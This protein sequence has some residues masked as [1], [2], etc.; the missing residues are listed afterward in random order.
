MAIRYE[1]L[2][3]SDYLI[4]LQNTSLVPTDLSVE[5]SNK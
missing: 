2:A 4:H 1:G 3:N 5:S